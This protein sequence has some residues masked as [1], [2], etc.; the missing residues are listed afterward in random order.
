MSSRS[1]RASS[2]ASPAPS[3]PRPRPPSPLSPTKITRN[4][5]KKQLGH[6]NNRL[7]AYIDRVRSLELEN[8]RLEQQVMSIE[9]TTSREVT[10]VRGMYDKE[11]AQA[12]KALDET[13]KE[14][15]KWEIEGER[16]KTNNR[17]LQA[18]W[19]NMKSEIDRL[20]SANKLQENQNVDF[21]KKA[22]DATNDKNRLAEE[23]KNLK[24]EYEQLKNKL[25]CAKQNLEDETLKR[26]DLQNRLQTQQEEAR[27]EN[28][29][30][31]QQLMETKVRKQIDI[32]EMD[33]AVQEKYEEKLQ[34]SLLELREAHDQQMAHNR[35][36]FTAMY[37][38]KI[39]DLQ[40]KLAGERGSA[41]SAIQ[42]M[43]EMSSRMGEVTSRVTE[44]EATNSGLSRR[45][46]EVQEQMDNQGRQHRADMAKKDHEIDFLNEQS[47][48]L[49]QEYQELLEIKIALDMEIAAYRKL[50]EGEETRLGLSE[51]QE[52]STRDTTD[53]GR[54]AKRKRLMESVEEYTGSRLS[55][56]FTQQGVF[57]IQP[58]DEDFRCIK[59]SNTS[60][61]KESLGGFQLRSRSSEGIETGYKF[62]HTVTCEPG[63]TVSVW[64]SDSGE[65]HVPS[66]GQLVMKEG[67]WKMGATTNTVLMDKEEVVIATRDTVREE[68]TLGT[69]R[70]FMGTG[71]GLYSRSS[72]TGDVGDEKCSIM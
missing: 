51:S 58:L 16:H 13:A 6:L 45:M 14:K 72:G 34:H 38:K 8:C 18:G 60:E 12:R 68:K 32:E 57:L 7:A 1:F 22:E 70:R 62:H 59:V 37:D 69:K 47:T 48:Q 64:S 3:G 53:G 15:A 63:A 43:K 29:M 24:P 61:L 27:F 56:T 66:E 36:G 40:S 21:Q 28:K 23:M 17:E 39:A 30:L 35:A 46:K 44:L 50:L 71:E 11:L 26:I 41:S 19:N 33:G 25:A 9:E 20:E 49:T 67:A 10:S 42:E 2:R 65:D 31:E 5:E 4:E 55:T 52:A 54:G